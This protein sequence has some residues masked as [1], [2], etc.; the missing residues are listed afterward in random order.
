MGV[1]LSDIVSDVTQSVLLAVPQEARQRSG[2]RKVLDRRYAELEKRGL[3]ELRREG[4]STAAVH[5]ERGIELRYRGQSYELALPFQPNFVEQFHG[6]HA[7]AYGYSDPAR[8][9]EVVNLRVR[10]VIPTPKPPT[11]RRRLIANARAARALRKTAPVWF[12]GGYHVTP[13]YDR[14]RLLPGTILRGP[15]VVTEYSSTTVVPPD[16]SCRV[17]AY[18]NLTLSF[19][20]S[21]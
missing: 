14:V 17:D 6:S 4:F 18:L 15:A 21:S 7:R 10:L 3:T 1:L 8:A 12:G 11:R 2:F 13:F 9:L 19:P 16:F 5:I 20:R